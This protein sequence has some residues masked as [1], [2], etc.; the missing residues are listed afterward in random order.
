[1][2]SSGLARLLYN[3]ARLLENLDTST[4][5]SWSGFFIRSSSAEMP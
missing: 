4:A 3:S 5:I 2:S 1:M